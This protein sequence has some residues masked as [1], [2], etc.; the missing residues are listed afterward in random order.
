MLRNLI[1]NLWKVNGIQKRKN[2]SK[3]FKIKEIKEQEQS[4]L[5]V[6]IQRNKKKLLIKWQ[7]RWERYQLST[8]I[9]L[10]FMSKKCSFWI[11][12]NHKLFDK[13]KKWKE[14]TKEI[15]KILKFKV[16]NRLKRDKNKELSKLRWSS[17]LK[18]PIFMFNSKVKR[19]NTF[20]S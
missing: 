18:S 9:K 13:L 8:K 14:C 17:P 3:N 12:R 2:Y 11:M 20:M 7:N 6:R 4:L 5:L 10:L 1:Y 15:S 16:A 19:N